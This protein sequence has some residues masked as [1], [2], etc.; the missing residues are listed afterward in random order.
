MAPFFFFLD[1]S[2][3]CESLIS[4]TNLHKPPGIPKIRMS[5]SCLTL[6]PMW[7]KSTLMPRTNSSDSHPKCPH[8]NWFETGTFFGI[9]CWWKNVWQMPVFWVRWLPTVT[10]QPWAFHMVEW[11]LGLAVQRGCGSLTTASEKHQGLRRITRG[12]A[13]PPPRHSLKAV[14]QTVIVLFYSWMI[15]R[16]PD[17]IIWSA[18]DSHIWGFPN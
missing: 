5:H 6:A 4:V 2:Q 13:E 16:Y 1:Y 3:N 15:G 10:S 9:V 7:P 11:T 8:R 17:K 18:V 14:N 12:N